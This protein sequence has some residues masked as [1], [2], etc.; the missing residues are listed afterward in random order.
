MTRPLWNVTYETVTQ[1]SAEIGDSAERGFIGQDMPLREALDL[2]NSER[3]GTTVEADC[4]PINLQSAPR[5]FTDSGEVQFAT[6]DCRSVSL[7]IPAHITASSR[8][9]L[10]R[11]LRCYGVR[12]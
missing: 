7:H 3:D 1:E 10:A 8:L 11:L 9:R 5:W 4:Y 6:G 12:Q 2:F